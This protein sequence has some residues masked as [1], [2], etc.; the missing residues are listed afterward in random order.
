MLTFIKNSILNRKQNLIRRRYPAVNIILHPDMPLSS[1]NKMLELAA[2]VDAVNKLEPKMKSLSDK[3]L[4][5]KSDEFYEHV[6]R[7]SEQ[8]QPEIEEIEERLL[9]AAMPQAK[10][11]LKEKL[12]Q[13]RN[14]V[15]ADILAEAFAVVREASKRSTRIPGIAN[16]PSQPARSF[17]TRR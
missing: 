16:S 8:Y 6:L 10:E 5:K 4:G 14:K 11:R 9:S 7:K 3:D 15:F 13:A 17:T 12:K 1:V 2:V